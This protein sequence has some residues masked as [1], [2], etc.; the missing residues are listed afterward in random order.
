MK[1]CTAQVTKAIDGNIPDIVEADRIVFPWNILDQEPTPEQLEC[2][3]IYIM[4]QEEAPDT[5]CTWIT[6]NF[7]EEWGM[8][9][10]L[11]NVGK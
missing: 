7:G 5:W 8:V 10:Q 6:K 2:I 11:I 1:L 9:A 4:W 3:G